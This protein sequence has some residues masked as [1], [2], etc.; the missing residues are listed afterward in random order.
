MRIQRH[1]GRCDRGRRHERLLSH[2]TPA[3]NEQH[4]QHRQQCQYAKCPSADWSARSCK[5]GLLDGG[6]GLRRDAGSRGSGAARALRPTAGGEIGVRG[7]EDLRCSYE[8]RGTWMRASNRDELTLR[9]RQGAHRNRAGRGAAGSVPRCGLESRDRRALDPTLGRHAD[10]QHGCDLAGC[11]ATS[12]ADPGPQYQYPLRLRR[13]RRQASAQPIDEPTQVFRR[14]CPA[15]G[16]AAGCCLPRGITRASKEG[17]LAG[18]RGGRR[19]AS[20]ARRRRA[21][22]G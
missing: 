1:L 2:E 15:T 13:Q 5:L 18:G 10:M 6:S 9:Q 19:S 11:V 3:S 7:G 12:N 20:G 21:R 22:A 4:G 16:S 14:E 17:Q 8:F